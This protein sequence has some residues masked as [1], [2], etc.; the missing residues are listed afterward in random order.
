MTDIE[1]FFTHVFPTTGR[2]WTPLILRGP[3][4][5]L[6]I[7]SWFQYPDQLPEMLQ[8]VEK[9]KEQDVYFS[10]FFYA[11][12]PG[13][14][15]TR[16]A[17]KENITKGAVVWADGDDMDF[18]KIRVPPTVYVQSSANHWQAC[19]KFEDADSI[20]VIDLESLSH[21]LAD[22]HKKDDIDPSSW[23]AAKKLRVPGTTNTKYAEP[24][25][26]TYT[27]NDEPL[28]VAEFAAEYEP[29][30]LPDDYDESEVMPVD[31]MGAFDVL[32]RVQNMY[33]T[34]LFLEEP[35]ETSDRSAMMYH[36]ECALWEEG[37]STEEV[38]AVVRQT[39][40]NKFRDDGR[41]DTALWKQV[42]RDHASWVASKE[43][44]GV[45]D[46]RPA[47][48]EI[49]EQVAKPNINGLYWHDLS[50]LY[51]GEIP[52]EDTF[53][54]AFGFWAA[55][56]SQMSPP[57]FHI[58]GGLALLSS[59]LAE[60]ANIPLNFG[61]VPLNLY[62]LVLGRTTQSRKSTSLRLAQKIM[63]QLTDGELDTY[64]VPDDA[65]AEALSGWLGGRPRKS[66]L[67]SIDE[68]QDTFAA[69]GR[70]N[71][72]MSG[73]IGFLT[74]SFDGQIPGVLRKTGD[75]KYQKSAP[76]YMTFY[77]TGI[78]TVSAKYLSPEK[79]ET[80]FV[81]RCLVA[82]DDKTDFTLGADDLMFVDGTR[83]EKNDAGEKFLANVL[84]DA[85]DYWREKYD[86]NCKFLTAVEDPRLHM[87][88]EPEAFDRW[89]QFAHD[90]TY[91]A[92][93]HETSSKELFPSMERMTMS[94][95][96]VAA[97]LAMAEKRDTIGMGHMLKA[98]SLA[99]IWARGTEVLVKEV[100]NNG[101]AQSIS[102]VEQ[103]VAA[104][105]NGQ[106][107]Y[108]KLLSYFKNKFD[109]LKALTDVLTYC[110]RLGSLRE[111]IKGNGPNDRIIVFTGK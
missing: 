95:L 53:I 5:G 40:Y 37:C 43:T 14:H 20:G 16:W 17:S 7:F 96:K 66:S 8:F 88:C 75:K 27:I 102:E 11:E 45:V 106:V 83:A 39:P 9:N 55:S 13:Q 33:I 50:F 104:Q 25:T 78:M 90:A 3:R 26:V 71:G 92:A 28:T 91:A 98:I 21:G 44:N 56:R 81:P 79:I 23:F 10:P 60:F 30:E 73:I 4:G 64:V 41:G 100:T 31:I 84:R 94:T 47:G 15:N 2:G 85:I 108:A 99:S 24:F 38:F 49:I 61:D 77:G 93:V 19:W 63:W 58:A 29:V 86:D 52:P 87:A 72:Y 22:A 82:V 101:L 1:P 74:K 42:C 65:T 68:V 35:D 80:G 36:I 111:E 103:Y 107:T 32:G 48:P 97:L 57:E 76:H 109:T 59:T 34:N 70:K 51:E 18:S 105:R 46:D 110:Q 89:K 62:F 69:A 54:D 6:T 67:Y 12:P